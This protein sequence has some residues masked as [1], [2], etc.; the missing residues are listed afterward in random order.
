[1]AIDY[2]PL[3]KLLIDKKINRTDLSK[4]CKISPS[5]IAR[6]GRNE[7]VSLDVIDRICNELN[8]RIGEIIEIKSSKEDATD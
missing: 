1:M 8:C 6:M 3:W 2:N 7:S 5:T 4:V